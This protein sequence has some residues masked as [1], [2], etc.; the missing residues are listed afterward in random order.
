[1]GGDITGCAGKVKR[2]SLH[3]AR[4]AFDQ[5]DIFRI[6]RDGKRCSR[7]IIQA[8]AAGKFSGDHHF[9]S[10]IPVATL[11]GNRQADLDILGLD[12]N[13]GHFCAA[14][15]YGV[16][17]Q[18]GIN[19]LPGIGHIQA[20]ADM[21]DLGH[22]R[23]WARDDHIRRIQDDIPGFVPD[24]RLAGNAQFN[25][26]GGG[27]QSFEAQVKF[28]G[29]DRDDP[30]RPG[31]DLNLYPH[32]LRAG[33]HS[34]Q[35]NDGMNGHLAREQGLPDRLR[36]SQGHLHLPCD[37]SGHDEAGILADEFNIDGIGKGLGL[38]RIGSSNRRHP[39]DQSQDECQ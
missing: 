35:V 1:M 23:F 14:L 33:L 25:R 34:R 30:D 18:S 6:D 20:G 5:R 24:G 8:V 22:N 16:D 15:G 29:S 32:R 36:G 38:I 13:P 28:L 2:G 11:L 27:H 9:D 37:R 4:Q 31:C 19:T 39:N 21:F 7:Y 3:I 26:Q 17:G 12:G 10:Q